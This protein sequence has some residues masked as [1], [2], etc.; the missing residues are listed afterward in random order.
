[1]GIFQNRQAVVDN[2][3]TFGV[4]PGGFLEAYD[5][6][7]IERYPTLHAKLHIVRKRIQSTVAS[8]KEPFLLLSLGTSKWKPY[9]YATWD[10]SEY[11]ELAYLD[12]IDDVVRLLELEEVL[13]WRE[14]E[15]MGPGDL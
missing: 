6:L 12:N 15:S 11:L 3:D 9:N 4:S 14:L 13:Y 5:E 10:E 1:M 8:A 2:L 7:A